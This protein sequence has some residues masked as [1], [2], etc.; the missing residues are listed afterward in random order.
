MIYAATTR[1]FF[2][3]FATLLVVSCSNNPFMQSSI[4]ND[5][6][7]PPNSTK[8]ILINDGRYDRP[9]VI[10]GQIEYTL[11]RYIPVF[12]NKIEL[13][14]Q[15][16]DLLKKEALSKYGDKVDAIIDTNI[17]ESTEEGYDAPLSVT[18]VQ[19]VAV[20]FISE[21][22]TP[23]KQR[24]KQKTKPPRNSSHNPKPSKNTLS[25]PKSQEIEITPSEILK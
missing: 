10:L 8:E 22:K 2:V 11:K 17:Q 19:G 1:M 9:Y 13:R 21:T 14:A 5:Q 7:N 3:L 4:F 18:H 24:I 15:A 25:K 12:D 23:V 20:S 16:L 6:K